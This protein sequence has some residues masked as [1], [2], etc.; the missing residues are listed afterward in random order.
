MLK[1]RQVA[2]VQDGSSSR[3]RCPT[4]WRR[5]RLGTPDYLGGPVHR[6]TAGYKGLPR[7]HARHREEGRLWLPLDSGT[8]T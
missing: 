6:E 1:A 8:S 2:D 7:A 5:H 3:S 4:P